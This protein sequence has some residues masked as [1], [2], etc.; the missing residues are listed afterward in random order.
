MK[1]ENGFGSVYKL[2]GKRRKP[3]VARITTGYSIDGRQLRKIIGTFET[4][5]EAQKA[6]INY[7]ENP[8][9]FSDRTFG[10]IKDLWWENY[11]KKISNGT[12]KNR[13]TCLK[14][15]D[16]LQNIKIKDIN[17]SLLQS[18]FDGLEVSHGTKNNFKAVLNMIFDYAVKFEYLETNKVYLIDIGV[19]EKVIERK[20]FS[21][22]EIDILW[23]NVNSTEKNKK[24]SYVV[25]ILI[26]TGLRINELLNLKVENIDLINY[27]IE[28]KE[29]KT[30]AGLRVIPIPDKIIYLF[31]SNVKSGEEYFLQGT[32]EN[33]E[34]YQTF[35]LKF[36]RLLKSLNLSPHTIHDTRH[37]FATL[38]NNAEANSTSIIKLIGHSDFNITQNIYTHKDIEELRKAVN[39][40][41]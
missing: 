28:I 22:K 29:S 21:K 40:I 2:K 24:L 14:S 3:W 32:K 5:R 6:L 27:T 36:K 31:Q 15:F 10:E 25:L 30:S 20:I 19:R 41:N 1:N 11:S 4:K 33:K 13:I 12:R 38:L 37:T 17:L 8:L 35:N 7:S 23:Q 39:L 26:Y 9:L 34:K 16:V 18:I